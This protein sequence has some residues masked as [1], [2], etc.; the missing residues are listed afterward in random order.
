MNEWVNIN[1]ETP[2]NG[3][4]VLIVTDKD[5]VFLTIADFWFGDDGEPYFT[6]PFYPW[7]IIGLDKVFWWYPIPDRLDI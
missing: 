2:D 7:H 3:Q 5:A 4:R 6:E 1:D